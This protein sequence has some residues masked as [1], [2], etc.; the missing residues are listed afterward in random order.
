MVNA[1]EGQ[2]ATW[3]IGSWG[4]AFSGGIQGTALGS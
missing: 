1:P 4:V 3:L 2:L